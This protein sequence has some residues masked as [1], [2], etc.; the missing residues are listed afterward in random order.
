MFY[1]DHWV[2]CSVEVLIAVVHHCYF[3]YLNS[4]Y[5]M[6]PLHISSLHVHFPRPKQLDRHMNEKVKFTAREGFL[7]YYVT[8]QAPMLGD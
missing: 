7:F 5:F 3:G 4:L 8:F 1:F 6:H 2:E